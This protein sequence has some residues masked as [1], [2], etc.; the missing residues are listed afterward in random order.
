MRGVKPMLVTSMSSS[1]P[2][3]CS[4]RPGV[5]S[6]DSRKPPARGPF[7]PEGGAGDIG[8]NAEAKDPFSPASDGAAAMGHLGGACSH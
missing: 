7:G 1:N 3:A 6:S 4:A 8:F 2:K 5:V